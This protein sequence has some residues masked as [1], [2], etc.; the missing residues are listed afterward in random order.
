MMMY[1][2]A[3][4]TEEDRRVTVNNEEEKEGKEMKKQKHRIKMR[5][6]NE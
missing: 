6:T 2:Q 4:C 1:D 5:E 3:K